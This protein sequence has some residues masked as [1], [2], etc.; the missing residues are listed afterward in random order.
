[1]ENFSGGIAKIFGGFDERIAGLLQKS[2]DGQG[3]IRESGK[4]LAQS[5]SSQIMTILVPPAV[6]DE[7]QTV[8]D[9][10]M[11]ADKF[12][13]T[14]SGHLRRIKAC[15]KVSRVMRKSV[16]RSVEHL[17]VDT[18]N[19]LTIRQVQLLAKVVGIVEVVPELTDF[20]LSFFLLSVTS[21]GLP[22]S[23]NTYFTASNAS[24]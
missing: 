10:P 11:I 22:D 19:D 12:L 18:K 17:A 9:L 7:M 8:L 14:G 20:D 21:F 15:D 24:P 16:L 13:Q 3:E 1:M 4:D 5:G 6:F 23:E 2:E